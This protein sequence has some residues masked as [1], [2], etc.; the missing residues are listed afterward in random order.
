VQPHS[1]H[2]GGDAFCIVRTAAGETVALNAG[3]RAPLAATPDRFPDGIPQRGAAAVTVPGLVDAWCAAQDRFATRELDELLAPAVALAREGFVVTQQFANAATFH[4][5]SLAA[6]PG[7]AETFLIDGAPPKPGTILRQPDLANTLEAIGDGGRAEFY[8]GDLGR[9]IA[10]VIHE[11][12]GLLTIYDLAGD[13]ARWE[14][15]PPSTSYRACKVYEQPLPSQGFVTLEALNILEGFELA[16]HAFTSPEAVHPMVESLRLAFDD[17]FRFAGDPAAVDV[18]IDRLLS[19]KHAAEQRAR[20]DPQRALPAADL[21]GPGDTTSFAVADG[22]GNVATFIQSIFAP[23][24][25]A[26]LVP[27]TGVLLNNRMTGFSLDPASPNVL[28]PGM[29]TMH[30]LNTWLLDMPDGRTYAGGTPGAMYQVQVNLQ[31]ITTLVD[32]QLDP[33]R[34]IDAPKWGLDGVTVGLEAR[35]RAEAIAGLQERGHAVQ[36]LPSWH[37][38][39]SRSQIAGREPGGALVAASDLRGEGAALAC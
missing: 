31:T 14:E 38:M 30:T 17:R 8:S 18:P 12:G 32:W 2:L 28:R 36:R 34:A 37:L 13:T 1:T 23:W 39:L 4:Y 3:G 26:V 35:F 16:Q 27:G 9:R 25:A 6:D 24:G 15:P 19:K 21:A 7:C 20:I 11:R 10:D 33:Q 29:R 22:E 5:D